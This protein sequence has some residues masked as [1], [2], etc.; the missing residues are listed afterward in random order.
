MEC[1]RKIKF[2]QGKC[3]QGKRSIHHRKGK[4]YVEIRGKN[5]VQG[6]K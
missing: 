4:E 6:R 2:E 5:K 1:E 3:V